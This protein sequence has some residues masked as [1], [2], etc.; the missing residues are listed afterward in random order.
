MGSGLRWDAEK[1]FN[2]YLHDYMVKKNMH[3]TAAIFREEADVFN[4]PVVI[5]SPGGFLHEWWSLFHDVYALRH[6]EAQ[7]A[8]AG[9]SATE[10][11]QM[12]ENEGQNKHPRAARKATTPPKPPQFYEG[13]SS[14]S[15]ATRSSHMQPRLPNRA[16]QQAQDNRSS[17]RAV[18]EDPRLY[19][20]RRT[21]LPVTEDLDSGMLAVNPGTLHGRPLEVLNSALQAPNHKQQQALNHQKQQ[22]PNDQQKQGPSHP[23]QIQML[24]T[25]HQYPRLDQNGRR[26]KTAPYLRAG[27]S[28][29][30]EMNANEEIP[31]EENAE[32]FLSTG[33]DNVDG[34]RTPFRFL[35]RRATACNK[36]AQKGFTFEEVGSLHSS[37]SKV[38]CC[39]FSSEGN[40]LASAGHEKKVLIWNMETFDFVK[41]SEGHSLLITDVRFQPS[42]TVFA[43]SS[44]DKTVKI[45]DA[46][47]SSK[48]L[49]QLVG[50]SEQVMSVDFHPRQV[51]LLCSCDSN[52][53][54][55]LWNTIQ[56]TCTRL[57]KGATKQ[58]RFQPQFGK[59]LATASGKDIN[60][61]D[62]ETGR[63]ELFLTGSGHTKDVLSLCWDPTGKYLASVSEDSA[64]VWSP[65]SNG[66]CIYELKSNGNK[67]Q[68]C[69]FH[70]GYS[71]LLIIGGYQSLELWSPSESSK[72]LTVPAHLGIVSALSASAKTEMVASVSHDQCVKLWK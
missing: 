45:W 70:P 14:R 15:V 65:A 57:F 62:L 43:T 67:F 33:D 51:N 59:F 68:S 18:T 42:S 29:L 50:H 54:V 2:L 11:M 22:A 55:R 64:R 36:N 66:K 19:G 24:T 41:T 28:A 35:R 5:N 31:A 60:L 46:S 47:N 16:Q 6:L 26:R 10:A 49:S 37:K 20:L 25:E 30:D 3:E 56:C 21:T 1:M 4:H 52:D 71:L 48:S 12:R 58:V 13:T 27:G 63:I 32:S 72:T 53:E 69:T 23:Q 17:G 9:P 34:T 38:V 61:F 44:F 8:E 40:L 7:E 39:H